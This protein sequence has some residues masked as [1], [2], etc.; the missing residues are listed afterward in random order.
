MRSLLFTP[1]TR[2]DRFAKAAEVGADVLIIDLEDSVAPADKARARETALGYHASA[3][4]AQT[5]LRI[6]GLE[7]RAGIE[8]L[9]ALLESKA[10]PDLVVLPKTESAA[11]L[12]ILD[13]L[14]SASGKKCRIVAIVESVRGLDDVDAIAAATPRL[15]G[16]LFGAADMAADLGAQPTWEPLL[17]TRSRIVA[18]CARSGVMSIDAPFFDVHDASGLEAEIARSRALGFVAK[19]AIHPSQIEPIC[20]A[21]T[22]TPD[23]IARAQK[24]L[25]VNRAGVGVLDGQMIDEAVAR[26]ARRTLTAAGQ[27]R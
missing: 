25:S 24:I 20:R 5:A 11:H 6:N 26:Q 27:G 19:A 15:A 4:D 12:L 13:R 22:P 21:F 18:A 16:V 1:A 9:H 17:H 8:D 23:A 2:P 10:E 14:L 7:T 3:H